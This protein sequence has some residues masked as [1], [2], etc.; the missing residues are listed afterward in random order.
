MNSFRRLCTLVYK[1]Y[2][3]LKR[4]G[5]GLMIGILIP[6]MLILLIGFGMS[7]DVK[8]VPVAVVLEDPSPTVQDMLSFLNGSDYFVPFH[9]TSMKQATLL[10]DSRR[11]DAILCV[12]ANFTES[13]YRGYG[14]VQLILYGVE[15][16]I[17]TIVG[18]YIEAGLRQWQQFMASRENP[19]HMGLA[20]AVTRQWFNDANTSTW[21]FIPG[22]IVLIMTLV[23]VFLTTM[24]MA[25]EWERGTLE[26]LFVTPVRPAEIF[27]S[28]I[29]PY[30]CLAAAGFW[31]C[32]AAAKF[33]Y[34]VPIRGSLIIIV[35]GSA[36][37]M[38]AALGLGL[39]ISSLVKN[40]FLACQ[41]A[42]VVSLLPTMMLSG[43]LFDLRSVPAGI[44]FVGYILP[45]TYYM[46]LL[47]TFFLAGDTWKVISRDCAAL[48]FYA[49]LFT[50]VSLGITRKKLE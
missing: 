25:R 23:G 1:E 10:M 42:L 26:L 8:H 46:D 3:Q 27:L 45:A 5:F 31:L 50:A 17:A 24:V 29:L 49:L 13:F 33:L 15:T 14:T 40:Q 20:V 11:V 4:D 9:V 28:K 21:F 18:S 35:L 43:F 41:V 47:K 2:C 22:L 6:C 36:V 38:V 19:S 39:M 34:R 48:V 16:S 32:M 37:Y 7:L 44:R 30:F 12:P